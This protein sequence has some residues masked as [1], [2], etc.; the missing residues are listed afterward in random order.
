LC[1]RRRDQLQEVRIVPDAGPENRFEG[2]RSTQ[3]VARSTLRDDRLL[4]PARSDRETHAALG[5]TRRKDL[6]A[7]DGF[8]PGTKPVR[9]RAAQLRRLE[10]AFHRVA[11]GKWVRR[12]TCGKRRQGAGSAK[13]LAA[14]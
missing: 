13:M 12:R 14:A 8:H 1:R 2:S 6:A 3:S 7:A 10:S 4:R 5:A 11:F 9:P